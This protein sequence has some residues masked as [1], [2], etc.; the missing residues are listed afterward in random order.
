MNLK[1]PLL[2][3][4]LACVLPACERERPCEQDS[5]FPP[6][7]VESG[8]A[9]LT[10]TCKGSTTPE[11]VE[12]RPEATSFSAYATPGQPIQVSLAF[13]SAKP[14]SGHLL[15]FAIPGD[16]PDGTYTLGE[17]DAPRL[18]NLYGEALASERGRVTFR[19]TRDLPFVDVEDPE[20]GHYTSSLELTLELQGDGYTGYPPECPEASISVEP[21]TVHIERTSVIETCTYPLVNF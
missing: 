9:R 12:L 2:G 6:A 5:S 1:T 8:P 3:L 4:T 15:S 18:A 20:P 11:T 13:T 14:L 19:R 17:K 21:F 16:L 10:I 7:R